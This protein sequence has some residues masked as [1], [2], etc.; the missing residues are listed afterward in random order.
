MTRRAVQ[1]GKVQIGGGAP[2]VVQSM[3]N[4]DTGDVQAT[5][6]QIHR[7]TQAGCEIVRVAVPSLEAVGALPEIKKRISIPLVADIHFD[8]RLALGAIEAGVDK[9]RL[10]PG[11]ITDAGKITQVVQEAKAARIPI[12]VG[13]NSG[14]I[15][16]EFLD[17][18]GHVTAAGMVKSVINQVHLLESLDFPDIVVSVKGTDVPMT[19]DAY[20]EIAKQVDYPLHV[21]ITEAGRPR[22]GSIR[23]AVG[24]GI[25]LAEGL[26]DT[27]RVSLTGDPVEEVRAAYEIL[28]SL[29]LRN[30]GITYRICPTCGRTKIDLATIADQV[31]QALADIVEPLTI[32]LMGCV[33][34]GIGEVQEADIGVVGGDANGTIYVRGEIIKRTVPEQNLT[35]EIVATSREFL[36]KSRESL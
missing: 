7:L 23:S 5:V 34:N 29:N 36:E 27:L 14:S 6:A 4:T 1:I 19:I 35:Q 3:T 24:L 15:A 13:A 32:A 30:R 10:N 28:R 21:G 17:S 16:R 22:E 12:R 20:R 31:Q 33:V 9:L 26:G 11:N 25:L 8:H 2:V 18:R